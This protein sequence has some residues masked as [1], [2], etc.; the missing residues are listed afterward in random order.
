MQLL[1]YLLLFAV[2]L[3]LTFLVIRAGLSGRQAATVGVVLS[4]AGLGLWGI[5]TMAS[6]DIVTVS[7]G[8]EFSYSYPS[9][10]IVGAVGGCV[11][12]YALFQSAIEEFDGGL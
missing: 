12:I 10:A 2:A 7:G 6:F 11:N 4:A 8:Q 9:L 3:V 5:V 1:L